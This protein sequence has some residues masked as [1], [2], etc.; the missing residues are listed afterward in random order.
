M[1]IESSGART[2]WSYPFKPVRVRES[3]FESLVR[4]EW[5]LEKKYDGFRAIAIVG[6]DGVSLWTRDRV[7]IAMPDNLREQVASLDLPSGTVLDGEIWTPTKRGSW[8]HHREVKCSLTLW[9]AVRTGSV[10][11][12]KSPVEER[13]RALKA[14]IGKGT[15]EVGIVEWLPA[16]AESYA[17]VRKEAESF[18]VQERS[19]SGFVHGAVLKRLGSPRRDHAVRCVEHPDWLKLVVDA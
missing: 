8:R 18:R 19:R 17:E 14:L 2:W 9:D 10:D 5:I 16:S 11:L 13:R 1:Q 12:S 15:D 6:P 4:E 3:I 7:R